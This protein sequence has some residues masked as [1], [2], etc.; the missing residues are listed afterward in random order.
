MEEKGYFIFS[1][2]TELAT[3]R[4]DRDDLRRK[5]FSSDGVRERKAIYQLIDLFEEFDIVGTWAL[6]GH[7][8]YEACEECEICPMKDWR[9]KYSSFDEVYKTNNPLWYGADLV[10]TLLRKGARQEIAFHGYSHKIFAEDLMDPQGAKIEVQEWLRV[11]KRKGITPYSVAFPRNRVGHLDILREAGMICFRGETNILPP[12]NEGYF[13]KLVKTI[14]KVLGL[15]NIPIFDLTCQKN[16]GMVMLPPSEYLFDINRKFEL[17]LDSIHLHN[18]RI[19]RIIKGVRR[20]AEEQKMI[21]IWAHPCEFRTQ[22]DFAKLRQIFT[23]V[24]DEVKQGRMKSIGMAEMAKLLI[25]G[26]IV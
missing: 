10:E 25:N 19:R 18:L 3:G 4:F 17:F 6:V 16:N 1:L 5:M 11:G 7:L 24:S 20:A 9:G 13:G 22:K 12:S 14:D 8:F 26:N 2:D 21:H 23:I 15:S